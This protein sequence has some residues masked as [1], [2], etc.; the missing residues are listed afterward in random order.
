MFKP[1]ANDRDLRNVLYCTEAY[2]VVEEKN[3][4]DFCVVFQSGPVSHQGA[5]SPASS[6]I[7]RGAISGCL[8]RSLNE[9]QNL[10]RIRGC[11]MWQTGWMYH[12]NQPRESRLTL[13]CCRDSKPHMDAVRGASF[14][15]RN[16]A[17]CRNAGT[18][19]KCMKW[20]GV[21]S[22]VLGHEVRT[23]EWRRV[24]QNRFKLAS[25]SCGPS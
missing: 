24:L 11:D 14:I 22:V 23:E 9:C 2:K 17:E 1:N 3:V 19:K 7:C 6:K 15:G 4:D 8:K 5:A 16:M 21:V 12:R 18:A 10:K 13:K 25:Q 20:Q